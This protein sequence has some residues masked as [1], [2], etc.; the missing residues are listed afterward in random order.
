MQ[1]KIDLFIHPDGKVEVKPTGFMGPE[2]E[3]VTAE[4]E[5]ALGTV[6]ERERTSE[7]Y[8]KPTTTQQQ[9]ATGG[10]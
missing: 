5:Q 7:F 4:I 1:K 3:R 10:A 8:A 6:V 2:C 9:R